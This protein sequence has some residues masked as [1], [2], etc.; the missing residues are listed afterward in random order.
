MKE[1]QS[2]SQNESDK[3]S[4]PYDESDMKD[5]AQDKSEQKPQDY[6]QGFR[7]WSRQNK[8]K[9]A[10][11]L[12]SAALAARIA[13]PSKPQDP[14][15]AIQP[16]TVIEQSVEVDGQPASKQAPIVQAAEPEVLGFWGLHRRIWDALVSPVKSGFAYLLRRAL[17]ALAALA[18]TLFCLFV[19]PL[20]QFL[21][22]TKKKFQDF[23]TSPNFDRL[24][25]FV[26]LGTGLAC[27]AA[28]WLR[29]DSRQAWLLVLGV[30]CLILAGLAAYWTYCRPEESKLV[31]KHDLPI[32]N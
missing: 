5:K 7:T 3:K 21:K 6:L 14:Q 11:L 2:K 24:A 28:Y 30:T 23:V 31:P 15:L 20:P 32:D 8:D 25:I 16:K 13:T 9:I 18:I 26:K 22:W 1:I 17:A 12:V 29:P 19:W 27:L 4:M 10:L